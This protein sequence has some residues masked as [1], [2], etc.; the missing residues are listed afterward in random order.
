MASP[1]DALASL[2]AGDS[3]ALIAARQKKED[4]LLQMKRSLELQ[5][6]DPKHTFSGA[7]NADI[8]D[9]QSQLDED[10]D[11]GTAAQA[12]AKQ[13]Q[14]LALES[15][16]YNDI[17][18]TQRRNDAA[19]QKLAELST[20]QV[21]PV[22]VSGQN[23]LA[24]D[25]QKAREEGQMRKDTIDRIFGTGGESGA[26]VPRGS[27]VTTHFDANGNPTFSVAPPPKPGQLEQRAITSFSEAQPILDKLDTELGNPGTGFFDQLLSKGKNMLTQSAYNNGLST[28]NQT[29]QQLEGLLQVLGSSSYVVG[30]RSYQLIKQAMAHLTDAN[31]SDAFNKQQIAEIRALWPQMQQEVENAHLSMH[32]PL[33][34]GAPPADPLGIR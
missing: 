30:S 28:G 7:T 26:G 2:S 25:A 29:K 31:G 5:A 11:F 15:A 10:P 3:P 13:G 14:D 32:S 6:G 12:R 9:E 19:A 33:N 21:E 17:G 1:L 16:K 20:Q 27:Q 22:R 23:A 24:L 18:E 34:Q 8:Q 4:A